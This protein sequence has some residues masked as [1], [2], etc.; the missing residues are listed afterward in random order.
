MFN[1][2]SDPLVCAVG[3]TSIV[4]SGSVCSTGASCSGSSTGASSSDR[5]GSGSGASTKCSD[6]DSEV[7]ELRLCKP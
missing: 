3:S 1:S 7:S 5:S 2:F 4:L 6:S